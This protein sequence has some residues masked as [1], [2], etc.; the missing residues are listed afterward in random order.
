MTG[1]AAEMAPTGGADQAP[2]VV[3]GLPAVEP[4]TAADVP[5]GLFAGPAA[6]PDRFELL[7]TGLR[8]GE[9]TVW[10]ARYQGRLNNPV[11]Y[12]V[13]QL[14]PPP[15]APRVWPTAADE[16][17][18]LDQRH[19][20]QAVENPH[21]VRLV[22]VFL[23]PPPHRAG[24][25]PAGPDGREVVRPYVVMEW[26]DGVSLAAHLATESPDL[27]TRLGWLCDLA[28]GVQAL[29][30][31]TQTF[32]NPMLHRDIKP[33]NC[34][35]HPVRGAVLIDFGGLRARDDGYDPDGMHSRYYAAPE[36]LAAPR[37]PRTP[38]S[39]LF[40]LGAVGYFCVTGTDPPGDGDAVRK[41]LEK[42]IPAH[43]RR[44]LINH[45]AAMLSPDPGDRPARA[46]A[47][48]TE[49]LTLAALPRR[50]RRRRRLAAAGLVLLAAGAGGVYRV[51][52]EPEA[53]LP[54]FTP[55]GREYSAFPYRIAG[56]E[57]SLSPP[58]GN[59]RYSHLWGLYSPGAACAAAIEFDVTVTPVSSSFGYGFAVAPRST[60][61]QDGVPDGASIQYEW[62]AADI[63]AAPGS[64]LRPAQLPG[65]AWAGTVDPDPAPPIDRP[66]HVRV[67]GIGQTIR[68]DVGETSAAYQVP[69]VECGG[70]AVRAWGAAVTLTDV[71]I[72]R[73]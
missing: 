6:E 12:A 23:G 32:G 17:R 30:S 47:W 10:R 61:T 48:A 51:T 44:P 66:Q 70:I 21:L 54:G 22:D 68:I 55:F 29:H 24:T 71:H 33:A 27:T 26:I 45:L 67:S 62:Q 4:G 8:G 14:E 1:P 64:Y 53:T 39:D 11:V 69:T 31:V 63:T 9:G 65:G 58:T 3:L 18:W 52:R 5:N 25:P 16:R 13:K 40:A 43:G 36:V 15:G 50:R 73:T 72:S 7:G 57:L 56:R 35:L 41:G 59:D 20:L 34:V 38:E 37:E 28:D 2:A 46:R 42:A 60:M 49:A 19:L